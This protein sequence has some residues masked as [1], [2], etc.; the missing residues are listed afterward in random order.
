MGLCV[1]KAGWR[2]VRHVML[3]TFEKRKGSCLP[4]VQPKKIPFPFAHRKG[5]KRSHK[6]STIRTCEG[7]GEL[8]S[9]KTVMNA[10]ALI[11][12]E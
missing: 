10:G 4:D 5:E 8:Q 1:N 11:R 2:R 7:R 12:R 6:A 3:Q 9:G